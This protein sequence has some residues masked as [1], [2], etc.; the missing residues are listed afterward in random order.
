MPKKI[1]VK[2]EIPENL[3]IKFVIGPVNVR[4]YGNSAHIIVPLK[5]VGVENA[6]F[7]ICEN[8]NDQFS[9]SSPP[10]PSE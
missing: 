4:K 7:V 10:N 2:N 9:Y 6:F 3:K 5:F 1:E 8:R